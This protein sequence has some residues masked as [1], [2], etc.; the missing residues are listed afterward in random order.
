MRGEVLGLAFEGIPAVAPVRPVV[1]HRCPTCHA[2]FAPVGASARIAAQRK[3][4][5][6]YRAEWAA[7]VAA[8]PARVEVIVA[9]ARRV[10]RDRRPSI[11]AVWLAVL[12][13]T[14]VALDH[15]WRAPAARW[16]MATHADLRGAF[17]TR[18]RAGQQPERGR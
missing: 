2:G 10:A 5:R 18:E 4:A 8:E 1:R 7:F 17:V 11:A 13:A 12:T 16:L 3:G 15:N 6:D 14:G 9:A